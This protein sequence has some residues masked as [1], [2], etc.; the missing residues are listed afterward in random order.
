[1][2]SSDERCGRGSGET[3]AHQEGLPT[4]AWPGKR[5]TVVVAGPRG[6][7][8]HRR[9]CRGVGRWCSLLL[10]GASAAVAMKGPQRLHRRAPGTGAATATKGS[11][12]GGGDEV[13][14]TEV[15]TTGSR[16]WQCALQSL[17]WRSGSDSVRGK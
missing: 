15:V 17:P 5:S 6:R 10:G 7:R 14:P 11:H 12:H 16:Q 2:R 3:E 9:G 8:Q 13:V 4:A 1:M